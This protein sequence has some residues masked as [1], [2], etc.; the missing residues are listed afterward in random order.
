MSITFFLVV[1]ESTFIYL[2][3]FAAIVKYGYICKVTKIVLKF[4]EMYLVLVHW[5]RVANPGWD[6]FSKNI[7]NWPPLNTPEKVLKKKVS[8]IRE[9]VKK[10]IFL[11]SRSLT[12][13]FS[14]WSGLYFFL[15]IFLLFSQLKIGWTY[16]TPSPPIRDKGKNNTPSEVRLNL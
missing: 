15:I 12:P 14:L 4:L 1:F 11:V 5:G 16:S 13:H 7:R 9:T 2:H 10:V 8:W 3:I 6:I